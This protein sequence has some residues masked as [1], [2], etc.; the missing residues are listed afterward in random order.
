M[1]AVEIEDLIGSDGNGVGMTGRDRARLRLGQGVRDVAGR[2]PFGQERGA[3]R[4]FTG[5][6]HDLAGLGPDLIHEFGNR[7]LALLFCRF[8]CFGHG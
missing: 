2:N 6:P 3:D 7:G 8:G 5:R 4:L 1:N